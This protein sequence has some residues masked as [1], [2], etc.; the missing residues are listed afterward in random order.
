L[1]AVSKIVLSCREHSYFHSHDFSSCFLRTLESCVD[2]V[3]LA[4]PHIRG[5]VELSV[6][7]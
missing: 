1:S 2:L 5:L 7:M 6:Q 3:I 4:L